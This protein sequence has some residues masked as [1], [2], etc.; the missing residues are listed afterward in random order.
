MRVF[1]E[2][3]SGNDG[4]QTMGDISDLLADRVIDNDNFLFANP[5][6]SGKILDVNGGTVGSW[7]VE[8]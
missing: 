5:G 4:V 7:R 6:D 3:T 8:E 1:I 2:I